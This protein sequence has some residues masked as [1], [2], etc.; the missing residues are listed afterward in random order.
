[1]DAYKDLAFSYDRLTS[2][3]DYEAVVSFVEEFKCGVGLTIREDGT[4]VAGDALDGAKFI[5]KLRLTN[6]EDEAEFYDVNT[7]EYIF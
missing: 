3:V 5:V 2:D 4:I 7:I 1:M 6:P